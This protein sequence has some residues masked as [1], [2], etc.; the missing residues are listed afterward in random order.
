VQFQSTDNL[1]AV[2]SMGGV[3][4]EGRGYS[5]CVMTRVPD[6]A[7]GRE[8]TTEVGKWLF[9]ILGTGPL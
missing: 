7:T 1:W 6:F 5:A 4:G 2:N 9:S 3:D 8:I